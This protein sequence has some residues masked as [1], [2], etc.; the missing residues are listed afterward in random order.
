MQY[1]HLSSSSFNNNQDVQIKIEKEKEREREPKKA[2]RCINGYHHQYKD[3]TWE[4]D[5]KKQAGLEN[6]IPVYPRMMINVFKCSYS[7]YLLVV[8]L[9]YKCVAEIMMEY[10]HNE[11]RYECVARKWKKKERKEKKS[12]CHHPS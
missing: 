8:V 12:L 5:K 11:K 7:L 1:T 3:T 10:F 4:T 6:N 2:H 9:V